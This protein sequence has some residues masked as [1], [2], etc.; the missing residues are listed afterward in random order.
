MLRELGL[1]PWAMTT[2][3]RGH[4]VIVPVRRHADFDTLRAP[5]RGVATL[6]AAREPR[7]VTTE[8]RKAR[9]QRRLV[10]DAMRNTY[11]HTA[12]APDAVRG[13]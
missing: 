2:R 5:A 10:I 6:A 3:S 7:L 1:E 11:G 4:H 12:V 9:R 13:T 8:H